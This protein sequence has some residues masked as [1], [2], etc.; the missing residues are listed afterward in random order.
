VIG[1]AEQLQFSNRKAAA[2]ILNRCHRGTL[3]NMLNQLLKAGTAVIADV[4]DS[5]DQPPPVL[6]NAL[7]PVQ[8]EG[9]PFAGPAYTIVGQSEVWRGGD[10]AKLEAIDAMPHGVVALWASMD[11]KGVCCFG[12]LLATAMV[13]RGCAGAI[14]DGGVRDAAFLR[15]CGMPVVARYLTPAQGV[16]RW[17]VTASQVPVQVR[18]ALQDWIWVNPGDVLVADDDGVVA[19]PRS[20]LEQVAARVIEWSD[21]ETGSREEIRKGLPLLKALEKYGHL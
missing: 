10:R 20:M 21:V 15:Q 13:G 6:D 17:R 18:G 7:R 3:Q 8:S 1:S 5:F 14:V 16:G 2:G 9:A 4:F 11:A 19:I 12:D